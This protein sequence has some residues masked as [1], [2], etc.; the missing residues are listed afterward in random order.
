MMR[1][2]IAVFV[3]VMLGGCGTTAQAGCR[4]RVV[5]YNVAKLNSENDANPN[6]VPGSLSIVFAAL[7]D[8]DK[9]GF[10]TAPHVYVCQ[11]VPTDDAAVLLDLLNRGGT[12]GRHLRPGYLH[13]QRRDNRCPS[14]LLPAGHAGGGRQRTPGHTDWC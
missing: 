5:N 12:F 11:E 8:D 6:C 2:I 4:L 3:V 9:P 14:N 1:R 13:Q 10:A 7:N